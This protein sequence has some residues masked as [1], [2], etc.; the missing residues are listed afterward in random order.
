M[1][2]VV[3]QVRKSQTAHSWGILLGMLG[4]P[5]A[6]LFSKVFPQYDTAWEVLLAVC[7][8]VIARSAVGFLFPGLGSSGKKAEQAAVQTR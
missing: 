8:I 2:K 4:I 7:G 5:I 3:S 6:A 1:S